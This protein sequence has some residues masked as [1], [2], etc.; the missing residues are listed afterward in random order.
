MR[1]ATPA[2]RIRRNSP[3]S[4]RSST[5]GAKT[6]LQLDDQKTPSLP[7]VDG[8][9]KTGGIAVG[10]ALEVLRLAANEE[11]V[12]PTS[13]AGALGVNKSTGS[14]LIKTLTEQGFLS[15]SGNGRGWV[16]GPAVIE[17]YAAIHRRIDLQ[18]LTREALTRLRDLTGETVSI[19]IRVGDVRVCVAQAPSNHPVRWVIEVGESRPLTAG[20][21]A[22]VILAGMPDSELSRL[23]NSQ[24][25]S[26]FTTRTLG[27]KELL[28]EVER[29]RANGYAINDSERIEGV[30]G[31][32]VPI[33]NIQ[34]ETVASLA[35]SGPHSRWR[36]DQM[37]RH[38]RE[39]QRT[40]VRLAGL[41]SQ[42]RTSLSN[43]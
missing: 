31:I 39:I 12:S 16:L 23:L 34:G 18:E 9:S 32:A 37:L 41:I 10:R 43:V 25:F 4:W 36:R 30:A 22:K 26:A 11:F 42:S 24:P 8:A 5:E 38:L 21:S 29:V 2:P 15:V 20:S 6:K 1:P 13:V 17:L 35:I 19:Q 27:R 40:A 7:H 3:N 28:A 33:R 14:R